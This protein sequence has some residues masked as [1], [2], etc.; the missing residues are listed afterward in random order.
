[1]RREIRLALSG[2]LISKIFFKPFRHV[3]S[4]EVQ[5][6]LR[7]LRQTNSGTL[8]DPNAPYRKI[9]DAARDDPTFPNLGGNGDLRY[10]SDAQPNL[11]EPFYHFYASELHRHISDETG[12]QEGSVHQRAA[13]TAAFE[14]KQGIR[15]QV[16]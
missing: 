10:E 2:D 13:G 1:M 5:E 12:L 14:Q 11:H 16:F 8:Y 15:T 7:C 6:Y 9:R 4:E 3:R